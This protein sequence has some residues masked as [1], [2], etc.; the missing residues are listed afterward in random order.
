[1]EQEIHHQ[2]AHHK[3]I[4]EEQE[5]DLLKVLVQEVEDQVELEQMELLSHQVYQDKVDQAE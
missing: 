4:Q 1:M 2:L 5:Q 3:V